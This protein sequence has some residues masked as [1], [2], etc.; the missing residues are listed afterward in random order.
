MDRHIPECQFGFRKDKS[1]IHVVN[2]IIE[3][4]EDTLRNS[5]KKYYAI[6]TDYT[7]A[8]DLITGQH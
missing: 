8:F 4:I 6:F 5:R 1:A 2:Y 3:Q 7:K